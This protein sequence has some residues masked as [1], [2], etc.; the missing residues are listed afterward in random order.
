VRNWINHGG[1]SVR[2]LDA[3]IGHV[4]FDER[5][6]ETEHGFATKALAIERAS[7]SYADLNHRATSRLYGNPPETRKKMGVRKP[8]RFT[9]LDSRKKMGVRAS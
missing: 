6:V 3:L 1:T 9:P 2:E 5:D 7:H 8:R 4:Q